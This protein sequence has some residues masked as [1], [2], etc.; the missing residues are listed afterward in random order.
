[1]NANTAREPLHCCVGGGG[2]GAGARSVS[3]KTLGLGPAILNRVANHP[4]QAGQS[5]WPTAGHSPQV[6]TDLQT[7]RCPGLTRVGCGT[8]MES[9]T[10]AV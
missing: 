4:P 8:S 1:M 10:F 2:G 9:P 3:W 6:D 7:H 5:P